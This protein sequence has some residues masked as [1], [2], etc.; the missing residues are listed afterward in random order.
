VIRLLVSFSLTVFLSAEAMEV[1]WGRHFGPSGLELRLFSGHGDPVAI[2]KADALELHPT[3]VGFLRSNLILQPTVV[4]ASL[5]VFCD[6]GLLQVGK[7]LHDT[8][9]SS[10]LNLKGFYVK[11]PDITMAAEQAIRTPGRIV[12]PKG[13]QIDGELTGTFPPGTR[14][15]VNLDRLHLVTE[16]ERILTLNKPYQ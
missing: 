11:T 1:V 4:N 15:E 10:K 7:Y 14:I 5:E 3:S 16:D 8:E 9:P 6:E 13:V 12:F 2:L